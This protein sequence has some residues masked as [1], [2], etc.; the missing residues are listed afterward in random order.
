MNV[1]QWRMAKK[2]GYRRDLIALTLTAAWERFW[3]CRVRHQHQT[4]FGTHPRC[5]RCG[6]VV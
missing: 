5:Y 4:K 1:T 3:L 2:Y 6:T